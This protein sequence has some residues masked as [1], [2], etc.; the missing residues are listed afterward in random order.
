MDAGI[1]VRPAAPEDSG[2]IAAIYNEGIDDRVAT[3]ETEHREAA[4]VM[5]WLGEEKPFVVAEADR[6]VAAFGRVSMYRSLPCYDG[7]G[8]F[9]V[10][11]GRTHRGRGL[12]AIVMERLE[13]D[14]AQAGYWKLLSHIFPENAAS[15]KLCA[16]RGF[17]EVG[18]Y[19]RHDRL[20]GEWRDTVIV[21]KLIGTGVE[22]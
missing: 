8:E 4:D 16:A 15:R 1:E 5:G 14:A 2:E 11:V 20:D 18:T 3:F 17:R 19:S 21:E 13:A 12:G 22:G 9:S 6:T 10:Y 7:V